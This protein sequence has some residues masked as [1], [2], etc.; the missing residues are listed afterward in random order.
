MSFALNVKEEIVS[1]SFS[2]E[3]KMWFLSGFVKSNGEII[4]SNG[5]EK[6]KLSTI[7]NRIARTLFSFCKE[8][9]DGT[10]EI[11]IIQSQILKKNKTFQIILIGDVQKFLNDI[12]ILNNPD[13]T[14][15]VKSKDSALFR[16][17]IAG[18]F[19]A[20]GSINSPTTT[21]YH[22]EIQ[23]K[24]LQEAKAITA[25]LNT[26]DF[27]FKILE[28]N[29]NRVICY[30]KKTSMISDFLRLV[31]AAQAVMEFENEIISRDFM[32]SINRVNNI[33]IS[34]QTKSIKAA[35]QQIA[36]ISKIQLKNQFSLLS[37]KAQVLARL[38]LENPEFSFVE[39]QEEMRKKGV[40]MNQ[41]KIIDFL[42]QQ[43]SFSS[44]DKLANN[45]H[46]YDHALL[47]DELK[48]MQE[49]NILVLTENKNVYLLGDQYKYGE[50]RLNPKGFGFVSDFSDDKLE[51]SFVPPVCLANCFNEDE[52]VY[53]VEKET[54]GRLK[55]N[56][57]ELVKREKEFLIGEIV[58]SRDGQFLDFHPTDLSF[59]SF[60]VVMVNKAEFTIKPNQIVK[61]KILYSKER[62]LFVRLK[63]V[64]GDMNK[65]ADRI[66][67]IAEEM[68]IK[69]DFDK[70]T[71]ANANEVSKPIESETTELSKRGKTS[72]IGKMIVTI[73]G[74]DSK[75]LDDAISVEKMSNGHFKLY[76]AIADVSY[77]VKPKTPLDREAL[78][79]GNS[80]YLANKVIPMLPQIL[81]NDLCSLNPDTKK[82]AMVCEMEF[83]EY[84]NVL[85]KKVYESVIVSKFRLTYDEVNKFYEQV[86]IKRGTINF[87]IREPKIIMDADSNVIDIKARTTGESEKLIEQF[88]VSANES[89]AELI[90]EK[91]LPYIYRNH[92]KP[93]EEDLTA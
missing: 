36:C 83:N 52:V 26:F 79:R 40:E 42:K 59:S 47:V 3:Q 67:S 63:K 51:N 44:F 78:K 64:I 60:R 17:Y 10:I 20:S 68:N 23:C 41:N 86:K 69:I 22:L 82:L 48:E 28:R 19:V 85:S 4:Y 80:T 5:N 71:I 11:S 75:D 35:Q 15:L 55:A 90:F 61:A 54:D 62:K 88:M 6:I 91:D 7:S 25:L 8:F 14:H 18:V 50:L 16:A 89:V 93:K 87:D 34:N 38:R 92:G 72:L 12:F 56:V 58:S 77:Y 76:V 31:D 39:L 66:L 46:I 73:D 21:N 33:D 2:K 45:L 81:S 30:I 53:T 65:A 43:K 29:Q 1:H 9:F 37:K 74:N 27:N 32:N 49:N 57:I 13:K 70:A 84:G 24:E